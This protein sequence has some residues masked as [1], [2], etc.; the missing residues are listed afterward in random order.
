M[1]I[2]DRVK[3]AVEEQ[4]T[5][6][7]PPEPDVDA[8]L[9]RQR[10]RSTVRLVA[11]PV[12]ATALVG[13][14]VGGADLLVGGNGGSAQAESLGSFDFSKGL[15]S[16]LSPDEGG[17]IYIAGRRFDSDKLKDIDID[18]T[19][20]P[21]GMIYF[22][23]NGQAHLLDEQGY[24]KAIGPVPEEL[25]EPPEPNTKTFYLDDDGGV[26]KEPG[27]GRE[28]VTMPVGPTPEQYHPSAKADT[29]STLA[30]WTEYYGDHV[31]VRMYDLATGED[32]GSY[33]VPCS[34]GCAE[35]SLDAVD[36]GLAYVGTEDG[37]F[38]WNPRTDEWTRLAGPQTEVVDVHSKTI[39]YAGETPGP[40]R[41]GPID[42]SWRYVK[43]AVDA[44]LSHD[45]RHVLDWSSTLKPTRAGDEPVELDVPRA[46]T[47]FTFDTDGSVLAATSE[48]P[49]RVYDCEVPSGECTRLADVPT[50][51]GDPVFVGNDM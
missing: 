25:P 40:A 37:T 18:A 36:S 9:G 44:E 17:G 2:E 38:V 10:H 31:T 4:L 30:A 23:G 24:R 41:G 35:V 46:A 14:V 43:G 12:A 5:R 42:D 1:N 21:Y 34:D 32:A 7:V 13:G 47:F 8:V 50:R 48:D 28:T 26:S 11:V 15:R 33:D 45:G 20:T 16:Y 19:A 29:T 49:A 6:V 22:D 39:L 51:N 3:G 27:A